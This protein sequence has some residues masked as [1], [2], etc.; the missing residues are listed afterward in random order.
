M[1][2]LAPD[3][4]TI[5]GSIFQPLLAILSISGL[6]FF[7]ILWFIVSSGILSLHYV[8]SMN[9]IVRLSVGFIGGGD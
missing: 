3:V 8:N 4:M 6:C 1:V 5:S 9:C 7:S 2:A